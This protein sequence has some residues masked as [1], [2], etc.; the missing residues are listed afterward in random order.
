MASH[1]NTDYWTDAD[2]HRGAGDPD[3][4]QAFHQFHARRDQWVNH[5][6]FH[7]KPNG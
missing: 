3:C 6:D 5:P 2:G 7:G 1:P 4:P